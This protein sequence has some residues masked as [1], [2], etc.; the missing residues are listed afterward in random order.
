MEL[1]DKHHCN[2]FLC[3]EEYCNVAP[4]EQTHMIILN[5]ESFSLKI[6]RII[7]PGCGLK[8]C[9]DGGANRLFDSMKSDAERSQFIP[10]FIVGDLD[11]I[12]TEVATYYQ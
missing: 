7:W 10:Q 11:S 9:A 2:S 3:M 12:R 1:K 5:S 6:A 4:T 8:V